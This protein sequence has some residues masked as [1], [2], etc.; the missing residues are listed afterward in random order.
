MKEIE[1]VQG[2][3]KYLVEDFV[4][5]EIG[6]KWN[7]EVSE[8]F[9][10]DKTPDFGNLDIE[11]TKDFLWCE[12]EKKD[13]DHFQAIKTFASSI[14]KGVDA[15]G[16]AG[17]KDKRAIT[18]QRISIFQPDLERLKNFSH[19]NIFLKNFKWVKRKIKIGYLEGNRFR[20]VVRDLDKRDAIKIS[21]KIRG[22]DWF[23]NYFGSQRFGSLRGNN[24]K[25][26]KLILKRKF[27]EAV[28]AILTD[29][30]EKESSG[31]RFAREKLL[32]EKDFSSAAGYFPNFLKLEKGTLNYLSRNPGDF[33]GAIKKA[34]RKNM[35]MFVHS[36][37]SK[38]FNEILETALNEG[39][40]FTKKGLESCILAG[41]KTRFYDGRLGEI[42]QEVLSEH[43]L[44]LED[45]DVK[46]I[47][48]L[49]IKGSFRKAVVK[50][51]DLSLEI[52][53]DETFEGSKKIVLSFILPSGV[54]ATTFLE[55]FFDLF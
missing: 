7:C 1:K 17:S 30:G 43:G 26:G 13:I 24:V 8:I 23:P 32:N 20:I 14:G 49:R 3:L 51:D 10:S 45:F 50:V 46:E 2:K 22:L 47:P 4:V 44:S 28:W 40:D 48:Y 16:Y 41:Y 37:Q 53:D 42:E 29:V 12:M 36:V 25:I 6:D 27:E 54:Y 9:N 35:L 38:I 31:I 19:P 55:K 15:I 5:E 39:I 18:S 11:V 34:E 52:G 33:V 21:N